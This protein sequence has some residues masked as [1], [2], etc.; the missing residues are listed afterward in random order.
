MEKIEKL[1][2]AYKNKKA[3]IKNRLKEL[4]KNCPMKQEKEMGFPEN[5]QNDKLWK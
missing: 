1:L 2:Y 4:M 5:W 3:E